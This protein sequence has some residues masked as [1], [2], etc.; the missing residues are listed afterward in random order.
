MN[1]WQWAKQ[2]N[3]RIQTFFVLIAGFCIFFPVFS[4]TAD[5]FMRYCFNKPIPGMSEIVTI[6]VVLM[7]YLS[8]SYSLAEG[9]FVRVEMLVRFLSPKIRLMVEFFVL[10]V[11][12]V[13]FCLI[14]WQAIEFAM[15]STLKREYVWGLINIPLYPSKWAVAL[16]FFLVLLQ[17]I[18]NIGDV[19]IA[20]F[21]K[22]NGERP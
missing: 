13:I 2:I 3:S 5:V 19:L 14:F 21:T 4:I 7:I 22:T 6:A 15:V 1:L 20:L 11:F 10:I 8:L 17:G 9:G 18:F 12:L 16:G